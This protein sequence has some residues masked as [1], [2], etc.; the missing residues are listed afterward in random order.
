[1][2]VSQKRM[3][4][5]QHN[6]H[7]G[8]SVMMQKQ[9]SNIADSPTTTESAKSLA[10]EIYTLARQLEQALRAGRKS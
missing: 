5:W 6:G 3:L 8:S 9:C 10:R 4:N 1:M 2:A 7:I